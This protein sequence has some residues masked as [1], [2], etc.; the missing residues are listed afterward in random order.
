MLSLTSFPDSVNGKYDKFF[1]D[2]C[3]MLVF[4][5]GHY[6]SWKN[7]TRPIFASVNY[8][9]SGLVIFSVYTTKENLSRKNWSRKTCKFQECTV[10]LVYPFDK[11]P[12]ETHPIKV[13]AMKLRNRK[14]G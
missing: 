2:M 4:E 7:L 10:R 5:Q 8:L 11:L 3:P 12:P 13:S 6:L 9:S 1:L 14:L